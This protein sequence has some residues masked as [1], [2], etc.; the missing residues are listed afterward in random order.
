MTSAIE[1]EYVINI[2]KKM[3]NSTRPRVPEK[4]INYPH[5]SISSDQMHPSHLIHQPTTIYTQYKLVLILDVL[6]LSSSSHHG[7]HRRRSSTHHH[8]NNNNNTHVYIYI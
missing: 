5:I 1:Y 3:N 4:N 6:K 7:T 2:T 8:N